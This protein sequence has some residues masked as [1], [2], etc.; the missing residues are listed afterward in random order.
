MLSTRASPIPP[1]VFVCVLVLVATLLRVDDFKRAKGFANAVAP[2]RVSP[3]GIFPALGSSACSQDV[4]LHARSNG[5]NMDSR[6]NSGSV[7]GG[8]VYEGA[9][10]HDVHL[11]LVLIFTTLLNY[12]ENSKTFVHSSKVLPVITSEALTN[13]CFHTR[14]LAP[15]HYHTPTLIMD[16]V[17]EIVRYRTSKD[18]VLIGV[19]G[20]HIRVDV[21]TM[22][23]P[24]AMSLCNCLSETLLSTLDIYSS[25]PM[26]LLLVSS[27]TVFDFSMLTLLSGAS[28]LFLLT[29][30]FMLMHTIAIECSRSLSAKFDHK[31]YPH[32][33]ASSRISP[34]SGSANWHHREGLHSSEFERARGAAEDPG[35]EARCAQ[36]LGLLEDALC[37]LESGRSLRRAAG[38]HLEVELDVEL[39]VVLAG[40]HASILDRGLVQDR[41]YDSHDAA[42]AGAHN[43]LRRYK[44]LFLVVTE[45]SSKAPGI[46][47]L[48]FSKMSLNEFLR[49]LIC[50]KLCL[51]Q[52]ELPTGVGPRRL[53]RDILE[54]SR[55]ITSMFANW[56]MT[57]TLLVKISEQTLDLSTF[58]SDSGLQNLILSLTV[59][60]NWSASR[61]PEVPPVVADDLCI[62]SGVDR[63]RFMVTVQ[64][65]VISEDQSHS[66][67]IFLR[68]CVEH[69]DRVAHLAPP[70]VFGDS[71]DARGTPL[72]VLHRRPD[73]DVR[74]LLEQQT[75]RAE[76]T[77]A[78]DIA[79][80]LPAAPPG[81]D[82]GYIH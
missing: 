42:Q 59:L 47:S 82:D 1:S 14:I 9:Q 34:S 77:V 12:S 37:G 2:D 25:T 24:L 8:L 76:D 44:W 74:D 15:Q 39:V 73:S 19:D 20:T 35:C 81:P 5:A 16:P 64:F 6:S 63:R 10:R 50:A 18:A 68:R 51:I 70:D 79:E 61:G 4:R 30:E 60:M 21:A 28:T 75:L 55:V 45:V 80:F 31:A 33:A 23:S 52:L 26:A 46:S 7:V 13:T 67:E 27:R 78:N 40:R 11:E 29:F 32:N 54:T 69:S 36:V 57:L 72:L 41:G 38:G 17:H 66:A 53:L 48:M 22:I 58:W 56:F 49:S 3:C 65:L 71:F 43:P 62:E